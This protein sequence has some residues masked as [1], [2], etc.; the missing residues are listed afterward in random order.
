MGNQPY[1]K[2]NK[3]MV[4][5]QLFPKGKDDTTAYWKNWDWGKAIQFGMDY[6]EL[7]YSGEFDFVK[8]SYVFPITHMVAPR[9]NV[10][11]CAE[12]HTKQDSRLASLAGFYMPGRDSAGIIDTLGWLLVLGSLIGV[13][14]HGIGRVF[15][16]D[17]SREEK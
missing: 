15:T 4:I 1:D 14:I 10:V 7:D 2:I 8:T 16:S 17:K 5:P 11:S 3:N 9:E 13:V 6:A 12:C